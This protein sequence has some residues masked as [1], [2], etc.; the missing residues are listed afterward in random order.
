MMI[1]KS[2]AFL[3]P[4]GGVFPSQPRRVS[5][6]Q[7]NV[8]G[9]SSPHSTN[10]LPFRFAFYFEL[11]LCTFDISLL[12]IL[13]FFSIFLSFFFFFFFFFFFVFFFFFFFFFFFLSPMFAV[14][15]PVFRPSRCCRRQQQ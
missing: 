11:L 5:P 2:L 6:V 12:L 7:G 9:G 13:F 8:G 4:R 15:L 10:G 14:H 1:G 3:S